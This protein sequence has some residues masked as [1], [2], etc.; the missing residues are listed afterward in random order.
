MLDGK[1]TYLTAGAAIATTAAT[2]MSG[3]MD[4]K[5]GLIAGL[6]ALSQIFLRKAVANTQQN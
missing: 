3:Q 6:L 5:S 1:K 2:V 4:W